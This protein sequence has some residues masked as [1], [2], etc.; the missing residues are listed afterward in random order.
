MKKIICALALMLAT[1]LSKSAEPITVKLIVPYPA[2][3]PA[4][5]AGRF[6]QAIL[7]K[8]PNLIV[9]V[10]NIVGGSG[11]V[12][13][14]AIA[15]SNPTQLVLGA[16]NVGLPIQSAI[17]P[18]AYD[19]NKLIPLLNLGQVPVVLVTSKKFYDSMPDKKWKNID[20]STRITYASSGVGS[21]SNFFGEALK[22]VSN[23]NLIHVP[24]KSGFLSIPDIING[25]VDVGVL[26]LPQAI[27][28]I[29]DGKLIPI[30]LEAPHRIS[31]LPNIPTF[32]ELGYNNLG[33]HDWFILFSNK[34]TKTAEIEEIKKT[35]AKF[36]I[37]DN[38]MRLLDKNNL[39]LPTNFI[40]IE[41]EKYKKLIKDYNLVLD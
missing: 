1:S 39:F 27:S 8:N 38:S 4:S 26:Y 6:A 41:T 24:Y 30:A 18:Q 29:Q 7:N 20:S 22:Q 25:N 31:I 2:G 19:T 37:N 21:G 34:T 9:V 36:F 17:K 13:T 16:Q 3:G 28:F 11:M 33:G 15:N 5:D 32:R 23:K 10:E 12:G 40:D 35:F 14:A